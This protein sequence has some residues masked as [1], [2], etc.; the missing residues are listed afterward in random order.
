MSITLESLAGEHLLEGVDH[1]DV[2]E[3]YVGCQVIRFR[4]SG[5]TYTVIEDPDDGYRSHLGSIEVS[6]DPIR[7]SF[8]GVPV[9]GKYVD[10]G[11]SETIQFV[12]ISTQKVCLEVGT[13]DYNDWYPYFV[14]DFDPTALEA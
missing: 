7:N 13:G 1:E 3:K 5:K 10:S 4:L 12:C 8:K 14:N 6:E 2:N 9:I 11:N